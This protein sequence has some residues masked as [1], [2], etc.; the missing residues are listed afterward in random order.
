MTAISTGWNIV[1][2]PDQSRSRAKIAVAVQVQ[3]LLDEG[4]RTSYTTP[5]LVERLYPAQMARGEGLTARKRLYTLLLEL[6]DKELGRYATRG[7][8]EEHPLYKGKMIRRWTWHAPRPDENSLEYWRTRAQKAE[9]ALA[10]AMELQKEINQV[11]H[12]RLDYLS[13]DSRQ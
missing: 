9:A 13:Q 1:L 2:A 7:E 3:A 4:L 11:E 6:A 12:H 5:E 8:P 10:L